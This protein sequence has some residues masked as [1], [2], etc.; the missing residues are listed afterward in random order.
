MTTL[1]TIATEYGVDL[2]TARVRLS[3]ASFTHDR[4]SADSHLT[5]ADASMIRA[6]LVPISPRVDDHV[7]DT[8]R[9]LE[10]ERARWI[11]AGAT[12]ECVRP[13]GESFGWRHGSGPCD[14]PPCLSASAA[15]HEPRADHGP[16]V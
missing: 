10:D 2:T 7:R 16:V 15:A 8:A 4:V 1:A 9:L 3:A 5:D 12:A 14:C 13:A 6:A 11:K